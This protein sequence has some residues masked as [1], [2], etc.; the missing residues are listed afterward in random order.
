[1]ENEVTAKAI[2]TD[3]ATCFAV[4][5]KEVMLI[6]KEILSNNLITALTLLAVVP[7]R[8]LAIIFFHMRFDNETSLSF[9][10]LNKFINPFRFILGVL[11]SVLVYRKLIDKST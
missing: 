1:M 5:N 6:V 10:S 7:D 2:D 4:N 9:A 8:I 3:T 11:H